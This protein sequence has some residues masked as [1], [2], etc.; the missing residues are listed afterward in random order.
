[1]TR[2]GF[3]GIGRMGNPMCRHI[4]RAGLPLTI[5]DVNPEAIDALASQGA[6]AA[7]SPREL[8]AQSDVM[9]V[10]VTDDA[11][12]RDV[13]AGKNGLLD[14]AKPG[15][16]IA[17]CASVHPDTCRDLAALAQ[18]RGVGLVDAPV[19]R[20]LRGAEEGDLTVFVGGE[21]KDVDACR[22]VFAAFAKNILRMGTIG[23]GQMTKTCNNLLHWAGVVACY[24]TLQLGE[25]LGIAPEHLRA[26]M[27][28]GSADSRTLRE[29]HL[30]GMFWPK[31]DM[32]SAMQLAE[33]SQT[34]MPLMKLV[35]DLVMKINAQD[36]RAL[37]AK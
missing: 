4:L 11:Q 6:I 10:M 26:A 12:V 31:K 8:A 18:K 3:I 5:F 2:V 13:V 22:P 1:M 35:D 34:P 20:G 16:V 37:L 30:I 7:G 25:R 14:A 32:E 27:L 21:K 36:L 28:A 23:T 33:S 24:E 9:I 29:L 15:A 19:A 17:I